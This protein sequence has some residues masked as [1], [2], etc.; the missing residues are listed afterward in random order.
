MGQE[1]SWTP[2]DERDEEA[3][4]KEAERVKRDETAKTQ[5]HVRDMLRMARN[6]VN[7]AH[8]CVENAALAEGKTGGDYKRD[9]ADL[10]LQLKQLVATI[11]TLAMEY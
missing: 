10:N 8:D 7:H 2:S 4:R 3:E 5:T 1:G 11:T 6:S 9:L